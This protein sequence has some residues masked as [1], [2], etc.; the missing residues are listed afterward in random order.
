[1]NA[2]DDDNCTGL[3]QVL[4]DAATVLFTRLCN[5]QLVNAWSKDKDKGHRL[6][7]GQM[8][9][10][11]YCDERAPCSVRSSSCENKQ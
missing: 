10:L 5:M 8:Q 11:L 4:H 6:H 3:L 2:A 7:C 9:W 1:M